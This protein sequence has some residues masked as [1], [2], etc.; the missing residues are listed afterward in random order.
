MLSGRIKTTVQRFL[1]DS[2]YCNGLKVNLVQLQFVTEGR[3]VAVVLD[4]TDPVVL[5]VMET[6]VL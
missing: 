2:A 6:V 5:N 3:F 4:Q 1:Y